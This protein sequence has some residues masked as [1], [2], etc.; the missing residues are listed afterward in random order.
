MKKDKELDMG[1][2]MDMETETGAE[3]PEE[4]ALQ[5]V[6]DSATDGASALTMLKEKGF[7]LKP[8]DSKGEDMVM[9]ESTYDDPGDS[10]GDVFGFPGAMA[11][12][13]GNL[14]E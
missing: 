13:R 1:D 3:S 8:V 10:M 11:A 9:D 4:T 14:K 12:R 5:E 7:E 2:N 6:L